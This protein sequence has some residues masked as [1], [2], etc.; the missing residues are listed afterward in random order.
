MESI[1]KHGTLSECFAIDTTLVCT[2]I[3]YMKNITL[4]AD[5]NLIEQARE[6]ARLQKSTLNS[7]F[8]QWLAEL[9]KQKESENRLKSLEL[10]IGYARSGGKF[11]REEMNVR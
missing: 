7:L 6:C 11:S 9:V 10:R 3:V 1:S 5:E 8:R 2:T 4:S